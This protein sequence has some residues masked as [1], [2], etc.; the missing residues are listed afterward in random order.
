MKKFRQF[1]AV[2]PKPEQ[3]SKT[4]IYLSIF[5][6]VIMIGGVAGIFL[7]NPS[8][9]SQLSYGKYNFKN[10]NGIWVTKINGKETNFYYFPDQVKNLSISE[11]AFQTLKNSQ[12]V[13]ISFNPEVNETLKAQTIDIFRLELVDAILSSYKKQ[14]GFAV[15][16]KINSSQFSYLTC[17]NSTLNVP[18]MSIDYS[19]QTSIKLINSCIVVSATDEYGLL[20]LLDNLK[21]RIYGVLQ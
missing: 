16:K 5:L 1:K 15:N 10:I 3:K 12:G 14:I 17:S 18:I 4:G 7:S 9:D 11:D 21:Y 20:A 19:N 8:S 13:I 6:A 2:E